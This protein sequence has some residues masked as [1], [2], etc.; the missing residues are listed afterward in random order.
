MIAEYKSKNLSPVLEPQV[1]QRDDKTNDTKK[2]LPYWFSAIWLF[3]TLST[4]IQTIITVFPRFKEEYWAIGHGLLIFFIPGSVLFLFCII[5]L[6]ILTFFK[7]FRFSKFHYILL[8]FT[9]III[10]CAL[11]A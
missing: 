4:L 7:K 5:A 6:P 11:I 9:I 2:V 8:C 3:G 10:L 1:R